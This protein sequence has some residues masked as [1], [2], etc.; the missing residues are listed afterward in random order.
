MSYPP[1]TLISEPFAGQIE[2][3]EKAMIEVQSQPLSYYGR[4]SNSANTGKPN[5]MV[6]ANMANNGIRSQT[7]AG[8]HLGPLNMGLAHTQSPHA[9]SA[10]LHAGKSGTGPNT[11]DF[12][13]NNKYGY[14]P[15]TQPLDL[16]GGNFRNTTQLGARAGS[17]LATAPANP[18]LHSTTTGPVGMTP[19]IPQV[20]NDDKVFSVPA[21][22]SPVL[23]KNDGL[24][25]FDPFGSE[26]SGYGTQGLLFLPM[27]GSSS[28]ILGS[29]Y[30]SPSTNIWGSNS[31]S[32]AGDAAVW[33]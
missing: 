32:M 6:N 1:R 25:T 9:S 20:F 11:R 28:K 13:Q 4:R 16:Y 33:G 21:A 10:L 14:Y 8:G 15:S 24:S 22:E 5:N 2:T 19:H 17:G 30:S 12:Y 31:K 23:K 27:F 26:F 3:I 7:S 18:G 29:G